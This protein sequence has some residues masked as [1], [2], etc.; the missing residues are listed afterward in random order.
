MPGASRETRD[1]A[2]CLPRCSVVLAN[3]AV[4]PIEQ[5]LVLM[6]LV[7]EQSPSQRDLHFAFAGVRVLRSA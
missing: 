1:M 4:G 6:E 3:V 7:L 2:S 5:L